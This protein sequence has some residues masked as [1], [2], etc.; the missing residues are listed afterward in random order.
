MTIHH[1]DDEALSAALDEQ[2]SADE[3]Q[4]LASCP[5]CQAGVARLAEV[6][7]AVAAPV[8]PRPVG[9]VT[10]AI[11]RALGAPGTRTQE[12][13]AEKGPGGGTR[14]PGR[15]VRWVM[16]TTGVA[17]AAVVV[18]AVVGLTGGGP[19]SRL[20]TSATTAASG[21]V[22][23]AG[24][25][26]VAAAGR[27]DL[28]DLADPGALARAVRGRLDVAAAAAAAPSSSVRGAAQGSPAPDLAQPATNPAF[29][30]ADQA[31]AAA[32]ATATARLG[33][34]LRWQGQPAVVEVYDRP[35]GPVAVVMR[36][37]DCARLALVPL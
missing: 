26:P 13:P 22:A 34:S 23:T 5:L 10:D 31:R 25:A 11:Q 18:A 36:T 6:A 3:R 8:T 2:A 17:A 16:A 14:L 30:C 33:A 7:R 32:G 21:P 9:A 1:L 28:G 4:H 19:S 20:T 27:M 35:T 24:P 29:P 37:A 12:A 15:G